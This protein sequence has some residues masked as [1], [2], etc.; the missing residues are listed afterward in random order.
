MVKYGW[1]VF[2]TETE[3]LERFDAAYSYLM[4]HTIKSN[5]TIEQARDE[6][7]GLA[8]PPPVDASSQD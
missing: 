6:R 4:S 5:V 3:H 8:A 7:L 2:M 1:G